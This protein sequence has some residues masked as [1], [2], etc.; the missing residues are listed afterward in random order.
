VV[1]ALLL[2]AGVGLAVTRLAKA[3]VE[4][5]DSFMVTTTLLA[6]MDISICSGY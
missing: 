3:A 1:V 2:M 6:K 5:S 4:T